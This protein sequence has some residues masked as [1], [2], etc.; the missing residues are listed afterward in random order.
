[1]IVPVPFG[2]FRKLANR[3]LVKGIIRWNENEGEL[4]ETF[5]LTPFD[6]NRFYYPS[7]YLRQTLRDSILAFTVNVDY[8]PETGLIYDDNHP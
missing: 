8:N 4:N 2:T 1:M 3:G 7:Q 5:I 6:S